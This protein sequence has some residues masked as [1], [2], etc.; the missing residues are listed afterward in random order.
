[1][2]LQKKIF[3]D[4]QFTEADFS[5]CDLTGALL[6]NCDLADAVFNSTILE[7]TDLRTAYNYFI[8]PGINCIKKAKFSIEGISGLL[9]Q[10]DIVITN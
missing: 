3:E 9:Q 1:M 4:S 2:K 7:K 6:N 8:N 5:E 10:Y